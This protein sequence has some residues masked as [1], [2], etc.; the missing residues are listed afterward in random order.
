M[1]RQYPFTRFSSHN[2]PH[3]NGGA[4]Y[5]IWRHL[6]PENC[7]I[8]GYISKTRRGTWQVDIASRYHGQR[9]TETPRFSDAKQMARE[10][11]A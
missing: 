4:V 8:K 2:I 11:L 3:E 9:I 1:A 5:A 7:Q 10:L 6:G